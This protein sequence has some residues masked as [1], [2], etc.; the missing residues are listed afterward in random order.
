NLRL[1]I[2][3][4]NRAADVAGAAA[5]VEHAQRLI[6]RERQHGRDQRQIALLRGALLGPPEREQLVEMGADPGFDLGL[7]DGRRL[8]PRSPLRASETSLVPPAE[9]VL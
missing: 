6:A 9:A 8:H 2:D 7:A 5:Q 4:A 3:A 1:R